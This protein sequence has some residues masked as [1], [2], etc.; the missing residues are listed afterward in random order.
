M[1][2]MVVEYLTFSVTTAERTAW[3]AVEESTWSRFLKQQPGFIRKQLWVDRDR[4]DEVV[5]VIWWQDF[6]SWQS[7][8]ADQVERVDRSMGPWLRHGTCRTMDLIFDC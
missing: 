5:A 2:A 6:E 3:L 8:S 7:I 1:S 4:P